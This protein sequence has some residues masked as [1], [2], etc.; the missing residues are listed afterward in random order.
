[1]TDHGR[2]SPVPTIKAMSPDARATVAATI[3]NALLMR[4]KCHVLPPQA[5]ELYLDA[6]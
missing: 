6:G 1:M 2:N 5:M 3:F 4:W